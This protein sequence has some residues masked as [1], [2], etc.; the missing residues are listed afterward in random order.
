MTNININNVCII[1]AGF[2][3]RQIALWTALHG[4]KINLNDDDETILKEA[5]SFI[6][7]ALSRRHV[8]DAENQIHAYLGIEEAVENVDLVIECIPENLEL[9][10]KVF[11]KL[12]E[13]TPSNTILAT[14]SSSFPVSYIEKSVVKKERLLNLHFYPPIHER[15]MV[16]IMKGSL[17]SEGIFDR[18]IDWIKSIDCFPLIV[19][20]ELM[21]FVF[22]RIWHAVKKECI[23]M[24]A[25]EYADI[26]TIDKAWQIFTGMKIGPFEMMDGIGLDVA[27]SVEMSYYRES[28]DLKDKP[29]KAFEEMVKK[30]DLG[31]KTGKGFYVYRRKKHK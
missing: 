5:E 11:E 17:T 18:G 28:G 31:L 16:D 7:K 27:Y 10:M 25:G 4:Y 30:G 19:K 21:G 20:K 26:E 14:N 3:G 29:P 13:L 22:N 9:K 12:D 23:Q 2:M 1:G 24:W 6:V 15:P 8:V